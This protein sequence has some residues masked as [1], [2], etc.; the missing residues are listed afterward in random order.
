MRKKIAKKKQTSNRNLYI[1]IA[2]V[3]ALVV[4][5]VLIWRLTTNTSAV[6][7]LTP[8]A[9]QQQFG[10]TGATHLLV[11]VRTADEFA[12]EHIAGAINIPLQ[13][14]QD[15][16]SEIPHDKPVVL[17]C[18]SGNR[19]SQAATILSQAGYTNIYDLG[20]ILAW[21]AAGLPTVK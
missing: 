2:A 21:N 10:T 12:A 13:S 17:Y 5:G 9:Y 15:R 16:M 3:V 7:K 11:D 8:A 14:I 4:I 1:G 6:P 19:S 18:H 20:G